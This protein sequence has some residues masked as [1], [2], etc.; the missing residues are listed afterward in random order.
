VGVVCALAV[1]A[2]TITWHQPF[3]FT[4][5]I[6]CL[7]AGVALRWYAIFTLGAY[8]TRDLAVRD[9]QQVIHSGP[10]LIVRHPAYSGTMLTALGI[11]LA[12]TNWGSIAV[13]MLCAGVAHYRRARVEEQILV[14]AL[15]KPY[16][17]YMRHTRRFIPF[18]W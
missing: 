18:V 4:V 17:E 8:F 1:P 7:L 3:V 5:G 14:K 13:I 11:A 6:A 2:A 10:Y 15:G 9:N 12:L 16:V